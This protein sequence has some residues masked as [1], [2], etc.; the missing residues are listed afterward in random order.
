MYKNQYDDSVTLWSPEGRVHQV[1]YA[2][3]TVKMG[4]AS[5]GVKSKTHAV[6]CSLQRSL[7]EL[8]SH[9]KKIF[10]IDQHIGV[11]ISG[12]TADARLLVRWMR[13]ETVNHKFVFDSPLLT[14][15]LVT[16]LADKSQTHTQQAGRRPYGVGLLVAAYDQTGA[17]IYE[18]CPSGVMYDWRAQS[19]GNRC[20]SARTYLEKHIASIETSDREQ[21][22]LHAVRALRDTLAVNLTAEQIKDKEPTELNTK[23]CAIGVVGEGENF[24][25]LTEEEVAH[26]LKIVEEG[27]ANQA[28][29]SSMAVDQ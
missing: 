18:T 13:N 3:E 24:H 27:E 6:L 7:S 1:E 20:Q 19:I 23:N 29:S 15:R 9:Q 22:I 8:A 25:I 21:L 2:M 26:Y 4:T 14:S 16:K 17:H 5:V 12:M 10:D 11:A 28:A